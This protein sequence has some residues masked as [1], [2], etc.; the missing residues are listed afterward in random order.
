MSDV[1]SREFITTLRARGVTMRS[2]VFKHALRNAS[3]PVITVLGLLL[4]G[5]LSGTV[6]TEYVF[7]VPGL[8]QEA[9]TASANHNLPVIEAVALYF[10]VIVIIANLLVDTSYQLLNPKVRRT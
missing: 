2:I 3:I 5:L 6:F 4:I 7:S 1:L 10:T 9:V 8:G